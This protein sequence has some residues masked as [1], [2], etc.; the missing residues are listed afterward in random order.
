MGKEGQGHQGPDLHGPNLQQVSFESLA[1]RRKRLPLLCALF[2]SVRSAITSECVGSQP[3]GMESTKHIA[4]DRRTAESLTS[5]VGPSAITGI[6]WQAARTNQDTT[7]TSV[8]DAAS[9][10][11]E[12]KNAVACRRLRPLNPL[13]ADC[14][15]EELDM[16]NLL[17][18]YDKIPV[19][20]REGA[21]AG[22][23]QIAQTFTPLNKDSTESLAHIFFDIIQSEF[24]KGR[25]L[26]PF[27]REELER[28][29][30]PFQSSPLSLI[31]KSRKPGKYC[32]VQIYPSRTTIFQPLP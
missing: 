22:I 27:S 4:H 13:V 19:F 20:I 7:S 30:G 9:L 10:L 23:P 6:N 12:R 17:C 14:W 1:T 2:A 11:T 31:P 26:G 29:I 21:L 8:P 32:L 25:Y 15:Q 5:R 3:S 24:G 16:L 18:K 28:E